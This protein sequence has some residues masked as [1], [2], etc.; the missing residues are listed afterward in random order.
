MVKLLHQMW[1]TLLRVVVMLFGLLTVVGVMAVGA[2]LGVVLVSRALLRGRGVAPV[3]FRWNGSVDWRQRGRRNASGVST[4]A[5]EVVDVEVRELD[6]PTPAAG[7]PAPPLD[8][9]RVR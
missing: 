8:D 2:I 9:R 3:T 7:S 1:S 4:T 5:A 6:L